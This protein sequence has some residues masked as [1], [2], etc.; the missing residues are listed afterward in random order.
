ML[1]ILLQTNCD[2]FWDFWFPWL[3]AAFI[4]GLI[5]GWLLSKIFG[6]NDNKTCLN[7]D[8]LQAELDAC[9]KNAKILTQQS[10]ANTSSFA[11]VKPEKKSAKPK[12]KKTVTKAK[13]KA[14]KVVAK[15]PAKTAKDNL[16]K[17]EGIG[18]KIQGLLYDDGIF[19]WQQ[20]SEVAVSRIQKVLDAAGSRY[21]VHNPGTWP[22]QA[23]MA[24]KGEWEKL[25]KWQDEHKGGR[26]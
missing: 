21:R 8:G 23:G 25:K 4:I 9:R 11:A 6:K 14:K 10:V 2:S 20:L 16:T 5:L 22:K 26:A 1:T 18:P 3:L 19:T 24:A 17:V 15:A 12:A 7:C 13:P